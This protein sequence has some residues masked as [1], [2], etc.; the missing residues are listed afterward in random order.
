[1]LLCFFVIHFCRKKTNKED[2]SKL[3]IIQL[4]FTMQSNTSK[5]GTEES[6]QPLFRH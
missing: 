6:K 1:M 3:L 2:N 4:T 5:A